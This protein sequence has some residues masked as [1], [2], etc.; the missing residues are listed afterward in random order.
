MLSLRYPNV[1]QL[2]RIDG[3]IMSIADAAPPV[4]RR[5]AIAGKVF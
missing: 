4:S 5:G 1:D 2:L 3:R